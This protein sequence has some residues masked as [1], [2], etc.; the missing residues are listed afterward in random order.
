MC[1]KSV[2]L[3]RSIDTCVSHLCGI[4]L[5]GKQSIKC[6]QQLLPLMAN[7]KKMSVLHELWL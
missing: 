5:R 4:S 3:G 1:E 6:E 2:R 7:E